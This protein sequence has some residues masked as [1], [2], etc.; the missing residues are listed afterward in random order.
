MLRL[1]TPVTRITDQRS[2]VWARL[3]GTRTARVLGRKE[4]PT[5]YPWW[6]ARFVSACFGGKPTSKGLWVIAQLRATYP[7]FYSDLSSR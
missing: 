7:S 2:V 4:Y 1:L 6:D 5:T 3:G